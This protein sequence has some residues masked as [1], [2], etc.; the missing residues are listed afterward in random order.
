M[1]QLKSLSKNMLIYGGGLLLKRAISFFMIPFYTRY[2]T[3]ADYGL[4]EILELCGF[5]AAFFVGFGVMHSVFRFNAQAETEE[6]RNHIKANGF[7]TVAMIGGPVT[8]LLLLC[9]P[10]IAQVGT[11]DRALWPLVILVM[12]GVLFSEAYQLL[13]AYCRAEGRAV[14]YAI[15]SLG[16]TFLT[17]SLNILFLVGFGFGVKGIL[18]SSVSTSVLFTIV[19]LAPRLRLGGWRPDFGLIRQMLAYC[20]PFIPMGLMAFTVNFA[21]R[22]FL[23]IYSDMT[24]VGIYALGYKFGMVGGMLIGTP[25]NLVWSAQQFEIAKSPNPRETY[26]RVLTYY[27][28]ALVALCTVVSVLSREVLEIMATP[29]FLPAAGVIPIVAWGILC[30]NATD[31]LQVGILLEKRT[32]WLPAIWGGST[33]INLGLNFLLIPTWG[34]AGAAWST[35]AAFLFQAGATYVISSRLY[36]FHVEWDRLA[37]IVGAGLAIQFGARFV[38]V[39]PAFASAAAKGVLLVA[40]GAVLVLVPGLVRADERAALRALRARFSRTAVTAETP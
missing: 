18:Y 39:L 4:L 26:G 17:L 37:V 23:R 10:L 14:T 15:Y 28:A 35:L 16:S 5:I 21:D 22:Y 29:A 34:M 9:S 7:L 20:T 27:V 11:G 40:C 24:T 12:S 3:P 19:L 36:P 33:V 13:L 32:V 1:S 30:L 8:V 2:L 25:F 31:M 6:A 38:P